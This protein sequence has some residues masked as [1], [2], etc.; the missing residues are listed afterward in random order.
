LQRAFKHRKKIEKH[1]I[2][3]RK[4][5]QVRII[6]GKDKGK[7][8]KILVIDH[9]TDRVIVEGIN[10]I[11]KHQKANAAH[12]QGGLIKKEASIH[13]SNVMFLYKGK[14][15]KITYRF[16]SVNKNGK[17]ILIKKRVAKKTNEDID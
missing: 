8:G 7:D 6:S 5:D 13:V 14:P 2:K 3:L 16:E 9:K 11:T 17:D 15:T 4:G 1:K 12:P 10:I